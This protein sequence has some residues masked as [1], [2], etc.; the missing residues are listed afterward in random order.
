MRLV[1]PLLDSIS[2]IEESSIERHRSGAWMRWLS[3]ATSSMQK[4]VQI[5][6]LRIWKRVL[7]Q[8]EV[9]RGPAWWRS[10]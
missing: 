4:R 1:A 9:P 7:P 6:V 3:T 2:I 5:H 10:G 8:K